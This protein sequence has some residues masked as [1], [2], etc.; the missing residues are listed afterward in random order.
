[1]IPARTDVLT[2][3]VACLLSSALAAPAAATDDPRESFDLRVDEEG[4]LA[5]AGSQQPKAAHGY[6]VDVLAVADAVV[7]V[8]RD[9]VAEAGADASRKRALNDGAGNDVVLLGAHA[10]EPTLP[11]E[12]VDLTD[13][14]VRIFDRTRQ[15]SEDARVD[16][17]KREIV[18]LF[19]QFYGRQRYA[20]LSN[21][22]YDAR[23]ARSFG[24]FPAIR[25]RYLAKAAAF[26]NLL[27]PAMV[28]FRRAFP[29]LQSLPPLYLL[30][31]L[32]EMDGGTRIFDGKT[33]F[34]FGADVLAAVH[35]YEDEQPFLHHELF[36]VYHQEYFPEC[37]QVWC[38]LWIEGLAVYAAQQLNPQASDSQ[39]LLT[40]PEPIRPQ[41][42]AHRNAAVCAT[43]AMLSSSRSED[44]EALFSF[45]RLND[46]IPP[47]AG[48]YIGYLVAQ[49]A[50]IDHSLTELAQMSAT[51]A[52]PVLQHA[53]DALAKCP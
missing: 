37:E 41:V 44:L 39:L 30:H 9:G 12:F 45:R 3:F 22:R 31:S 14:Y 23:I 28:T 46:A 11:Y 53:V 26:Q 4:L 15:L 16:A 21:E 48:Y 47:R 2:L 17:F 35:D 34:V 36:H 8:A 32:G 13:D 50:G 10:A 38:S 5:P 40:Q 49:R 42:D 43:R 7:V 27:Q 24:S 18:P 19:Q 1:M 20:D 51:A 6:G 29:D 25:E 33:A 52:R